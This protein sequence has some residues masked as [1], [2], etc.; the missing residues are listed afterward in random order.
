MI[1]Q[2]FDTWNDN[3]ITTTVETLPKPD[4]SFFRYFFSLA[5]V[6]NRYIMLSGGKNQTDVLSSH[7]YIFDTME[8]RWLNRDLIPKLGTA[9][10][11]HSSCATSASG[12]FFQGFNKK[13]MILDT[14]EQVPLSFAPF[15]GQGKKSQIAVRSIAPPACLLLAAISDH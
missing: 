9:R 1:Y 5:V 13:G 15:H 8:K 10:Y 6:K 12:F 4:Q 11:T 7:I 14:L 3:P 2:S